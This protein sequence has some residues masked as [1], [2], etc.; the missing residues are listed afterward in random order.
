MKRYGIYYRIK[1]IVPRFV[2]LRARI[3]AARKKRKKYCDIWPIDPDCNQAPEGWIGWPGGNKFAIVLTHDVESQ[4]GQEKAKKLATVEKTL[5]FRSSFNLVPEKRYKTSYELRQWLQEN[6]FEIGV[7]DLNHD[8]RLYNSKKIFSKR[9]IKINRYLK[10]WNAKGFRSGSMLH[11]LEW[12]GMLDVEYDEST[13]DTDPFEPQPDGVATIFPFCVERK[14]GPPF[15]ELP[16]TLPQDFTIFVLF[17]E[18]T[19]D[20]W[21]Q[22]LD[23]I[24]QHGGMALMNVHPDYINFRD[25]PIKNDQYPIEYYRKFLEYCIDKYSGEYWN[26]LPKQVAQY[27]LGAKTFQ[28]TNE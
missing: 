7:H 22:K 21:K 10:D 12:L 25:A 27:I 13:F 11:N 20:I 4:E 9:A 16:Y 3:A 28:K 14:N 5:G 2:R 8:G 26:P 17:R 6:D 15:V 19:I 23:W 1:P 24:A 18:K